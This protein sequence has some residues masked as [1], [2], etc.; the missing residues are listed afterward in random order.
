MNVVNLID[1]RRHW[2]LNCNT[3]FRLHELIQHLQLDECPVLTSR[4]KHPSSIGV[5]S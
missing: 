5:P 2:C 1:Y 4:A 3:E